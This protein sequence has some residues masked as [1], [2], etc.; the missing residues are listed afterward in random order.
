MGCPP[1]CGQTNRFGLEALRDVRGDLPPWSHA[2]HHPWL[3]LAAPARSALQCPVSR[4][5]P[6]A[7]HRT[8][9]LTSGPI[10][11]TSTALIDDHPMSDAEPGVT[12]IDAAHALAGLVAAH[13]P[14]PSRIRAHSR[15]T[16]ST[17]FPER[18]NSADGG[19]AAPPARWGVISL[20]PQGT[21][22]ATKNPR[23]AGGFSVGGTGIEPVSR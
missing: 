6:I 4:F 8:P 22:G 20:S 12:A 11:E 5:P 16:R 19:A 21:I 18:Q 3:A 9:S 15:R 13:L 14:R 23:S 2:A 17:R 10:L 7:R 1:K